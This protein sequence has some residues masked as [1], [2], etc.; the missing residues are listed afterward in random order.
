MASQATL[1]SE[2]SA[3]WS[4]EEAG[5]TAIHVPNQTIKEMEPIAEEKDASEADDA[6]REKSKS[7][8][9]ASDAKSLEEI[10]VPKRHPS[11]VVGTDTDSDAIPASKLETASSRPK[12]THGKSIPAKSSKGV[13]YPGVE[14][15]YPL[16]F[17]EDEGYDA[18][19]GSIRRSTLA[20]RRA[21]RSRRQ[22][23]Q[24][25]GESP[26]HKDSAFLLDPAR[27]GLAIEHDRMN[28]GDLLRSRN[29]RTESESLQP[30]RTL[31]P[32][33]FDP[34]PDWS[35]LLTQEITQYANQR[36]S[37]LPPRVP[38]PRFPLPRVPR[39]IDQ[40]ATGRYPQPAVRTIQS[41]YHAYSDDDRNRKTGFLE[42]YSGYS[43]SS[44]RIRFESH[45]PTR[46]QAAGLP[47]TH[48]VDSRGREN[49]PNDTA[50]SGRWRVR[51]PD[52]PEDRKGQHGVY[53]V[54]SSEN[55][56]EEDALYVV[57]GRRQR[58]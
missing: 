40:I 5:N 11:G 43:G 28:K 51:R 49:K 13:R 36:Y 31:V 55:G 17:E 48:Q 25:K 18:D 23:G 58:R 22:N 45:P 10:V 4:D 50:N 3:A 44:P 15:Q 46:H 27:A 41:T 19:V 57:G 32:F 34:E 33:S 16:H 39:T 37:A 7:D 20:K 14:G 42:D 2:A 9:N 24:R 21:E 6:P 35:P 1:F 47:V 38:R 52:S 8:D 12:T 54:G 56:R 29:K 53:G 26:Q 30:N